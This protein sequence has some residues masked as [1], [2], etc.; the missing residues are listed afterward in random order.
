[1]G[2]W[3]VQRCLGVTKFYCQ[4]Y[5][6]KYEEVLARIAFYVVAALATF[7]LCCLSADRRIPLLTAFGRNS[8]WI[9]LLHRPATIVASRWFCRGTATTAMVGAAALT[10][11]IALASGNWWIVRPLDRL[12]DQGGRLLTERDHR[13]TGA[14]RIAVLVV[15]LGFIVKLLAGAVAADS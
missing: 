14:A 5:G 2:M 3:V 9:Y 12:A 13:K 7:A 6:G 8:L 15:A 4:S 11:L 1:M 10:L